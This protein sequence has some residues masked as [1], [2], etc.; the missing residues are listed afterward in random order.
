MRAISLPV[1]LA[2]ALLCV[3]AHAEQ[4]YPVLSTK[5]YPTAKGAATGG[6][7]YAITRGI[8]RRKLLGSF[9]VFNSRQVTVTEGQ[10]NRFS[11][12]ARKTN[13]DNGQ[14][15]AKTSVNVVRTRRGKFHFIDPAAVSLNLPI[16]TTAKNRHSAARAAGA[17][18]MLK[19]GEVKRWFASDGVEGADVI[20]KLSAS[21]EKVSSSGKT[22]RVRVYTRSNGQ[23]GFPMVETAVWVRQLKSGQWRGYDKN[24]ALQINDLW[25]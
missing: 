7:A 15:L 21:V 2:V 1:F 12:Q 9:G 19:N 3:T 13:P 25:E 5:S 24:A 23:D 6:G 20:K 11:I 10:G 4:R 16:L 14:P 22:A 18:A 17:K 8:A